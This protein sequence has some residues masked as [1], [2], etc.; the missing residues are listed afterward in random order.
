[1]P[2]FARAVTDADDIAVAAT[3]L[4]EAEDRP[5]Q[6]CAFDETAKSFGELRPV[7]AQ[8]GLVERAF[9]GET[10][11]GRD[12]GSHAFDWLCAR[13]DFFYVDSGRQILRHSASSV[14]R[15]ATHDPGPSGRCGGGTAGRSR[16][17]QEVHLRAGIG[18][19]SG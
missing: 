1:M 16:G 13:V 12:G 6:G 7:A 8:S 4:E 14:D 5:C 3:V 9:L 15:W 2:V 18:P 17:H 10:N 11:E 19:R